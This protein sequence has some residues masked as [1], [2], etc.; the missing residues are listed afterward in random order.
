LRD[1]LTEVRE[2]IATVPRE[3]RQLL[4]LIGR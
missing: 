4:R 2:L 3:G 1:G